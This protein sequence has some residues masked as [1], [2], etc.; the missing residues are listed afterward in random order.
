M[1][2]GPK[3]ANLAPPSSGAIEATCVHGLRAFPTSPSPARSWSHPA[4]ARPF[5][6]SRHP[7]G[8]L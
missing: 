6:V 4:W 8:L 2:V 7:A 3:S 1:A 5:E